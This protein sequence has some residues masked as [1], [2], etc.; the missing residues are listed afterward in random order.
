MRKSYAELG[1]HP[2]ES[3]SVPFHDILKTMSGFL[4]FEAE[5]DQTDGCFTLT[6]FLWIYS[7]QVS[8]DGQKL[9]E[10][11]LATFRHLSHFLHRFTYCP[12][13]KTIV[14]F[15]SVLVLFTL[16]CWEMVGRTLIF[17]F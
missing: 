10:M 16:L 6:S 1:T 11:D 4:S 2:E 7:A 14:P 5:I 12:T 9:F 13:D 3:T 17:I 8:L 15:S